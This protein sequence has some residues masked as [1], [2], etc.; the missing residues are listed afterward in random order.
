MAVQLL[1]MAAYTEDDDTDEEADADGETDRSQH[2]PGR[3]HA[4][5][6]AATQSCANNKRDLSPV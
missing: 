1:I 3:S 2:V 4:Q 5:R 6:V